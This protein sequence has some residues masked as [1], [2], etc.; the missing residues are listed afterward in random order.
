MIKKMKFLLLLLFA[1]NFINLFSMENSNFEYTILLPVD[2][3]ESQGKRLNYK[4]KVPKEFR[5]ISNGGTTINEFIPKSENENQWYQIITTQ[6]CRNQ[7][8]CR[9]YDWSIKT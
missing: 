3:S 5:K 7:I 9:F 2:V 6:Y 1:F 8:T 4:V